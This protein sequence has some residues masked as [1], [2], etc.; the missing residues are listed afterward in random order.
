[1]NVLVLGANGQLAR[2]TVPVFLRAGWK[3]ALDPARELRHEIG[4][5]RV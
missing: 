3:L 4:I 5:S 1:M 2:H